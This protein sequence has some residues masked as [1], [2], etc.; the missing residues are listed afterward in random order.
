MENG[1]LAPGVRTLAVETLPAPNPVLRTS[2]SIPARVTKARLY[3]VG[4][5]YGAFSINGRSLGNELEP[6]TTDF[7]KTVLYRTYDVTDALHSG[8]NTLEV[9]LGR[10][11]FSARGASIWGWHVAPWSREPMAVA[12]LEYVDQAGKRHIISSDSHWKASTGKIKSELLYSGEVWQMQ[13]EEEPAW[14]PVVLVDPPTG[15]LRPA[16]L[17]PV[18]L[19]SAKPPA[20]MH[21]AGTARVYDFAEMVAGR[22]RCTLS[23][24]GATEVWVKYGET[25]DDGGAVFCENQ[26][27][28]GPIQMD[29]LLFDSSAD[30]ICWEPKF[31]YKGYRYVSIEAAESVTV[32]DIV[33]VP[34]H[35]D[36]QPVGT[37]ECNEETLSWLGR[38]LANTFLNNLHGIPTDTPVYEKNGWTADAHLA[39]EALIHHFDLK[40][41]FNKWLDDHADAQDDAG[42]VPNIIPTPGWGRNPDPAWSASAV[43]IPWNLYWEY[44]DIK[45]LERHHEMVIRYAD[46]MYALSEE[47]I[48]RRPS[49]GDWLAPGYERAPEGSAPT[50]TM[51]LLKVL[52]T[53]ADISTALGEHGIAES[54]SARA[55]LVGTAYH[56]SFFNKN[57][58]SYGTESFGYRQTMNVLPLAF[59]A[60]PQQLRDTV[61]RSLVTDILE[62]TDGHLDCG[63][64]GAKY[65]LPVLS[66][67]GRDDLALSVATQNTRPG[68]GVWR[69]A[70][71]TTLLESWDISARSHNHYFL[72]SAAA[73]VQQKVGGLRSTR[74]G[75]EEFDVAPVADPRLT[76]GALSHLT[77]RGQ[78][79]ISWTR[80]AGTWLLD[81][82]VP[83]GAT[84]TIGVGAAAGTKLSGGF[85]R[86]E[87]EDAPPVL[88]STI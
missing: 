21:Y 28:A 24:P 79:A 37:F 12:Q 8:D 67:G 80:E 54:F 10:G 51:M 30:R 57:L 59:G 25:L 13:A 75:W 82:T 78:A 71:E 20:S 11:F 62:R 61:F 4:L 66:G 65:L 18:T 34:M 22:V 76:R 44:G 83:W 45:F 7:S 52:S 84:A 38:A 3:A 85:H 47:G 16:G 64:V 40:S 32:H 29:R 68:W 72:G 2:F 70:G 53:A 35:T 56:Q 41:T 86:L 39:A 43:L 5:G 87:F 60:V 27:A 26:L 31:S 69:E 50:A 73:W 42:V 46:A 33:S 63:A 81:V 17:P 55:S 77:P 9:E 48:W 6:A 74:P 1:V 36:V 58:G 23:V 49:Y 15:T 88:S 19:G 14:E